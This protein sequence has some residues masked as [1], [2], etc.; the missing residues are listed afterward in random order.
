M[1]AY[2]FDTNSLS[3]ALNEQGGVLERINQA[4]LQGHQLLT[5]S[6]VVA[7][8][9]YGAELSARRDEA[10]RSSPTTTTSTRRTCRPS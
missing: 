4:G 10:R 9:L 1:T 3:Y 7:E 6:I 5:S 2:L 8:L